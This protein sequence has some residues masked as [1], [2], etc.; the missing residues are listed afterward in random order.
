MNVSRRHFLKEAF[1]ALGFAALPGGMI[2]AAPEGWKPKGAPNLVFGVISDTHLRTTPTCGRIDRKWSAK[3]LVKAFQ[4][5]KSVNVDAVVHC[6]DFADHGQIEEMQGHADAWKKVFP[7][8]RAPD[9]H[10]VVRL[11]VAGNHD[12]EGSNYGNKGQFVKRIYPDPAERAKHTLSTDM[13]ANWKRIWG[14]EYSDTWH[15]EVKG[16]HFF[17]IQWGVDDGRI[18]DLVDETACCAPPKPFFLIRHVFPSVALRKRIGKHPN[19]VGIFGH[20][21]YSIAD[22]KRIY[23]AEGIPWIQTPALHSRGY[24]GLRE[25]DASLPGAKFEGLGAAGSKLARQGMVVRLYD[26]MMVIER[27]EFGAGGSLGPDWVM[28]FGQYKPHPFSKGEMKK[29]IGK[30][31]FR[32]DARLEICNSENVANVEMLPIAKSNVANEGGKP[33]WKLGT[34]TGNNGNTGNNL[35]LKIPPADGN[36]NSRVYAY[37]VAISG[38]E[39]SEKLVK[40]VYAAGCNM[41]LGHE[42]NGGV[43]TL[44]I[45]KSELPKSKSLKIAV[46]PV[47][48]L[49]TKG[50]AISADWKLS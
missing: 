37:E 15:R 25:S 46:T 17:G 49:G 23:F 10:E 27:R 7:R 32:K 38:E 40:A 11:F 12:V 26:D 39:G 16:Y 47:S 45:S 13:A 42:P 44:S 6:G 19:A 24:D 21:H 14:E 29:T 30:P 20:F 34:G 36:V 28:P 22:W 8:N 9:G 18:A 1:A 5:F 48:S 31:Q 41:G 4:Y 3:Y 50:K 35:I 43:T 2:F 33:N